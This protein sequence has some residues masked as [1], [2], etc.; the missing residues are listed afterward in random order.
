MTPALYVILA[1]ALALSLLWGY[2]ATVWW[3][4]RKHGGI[5]PSDLQQRGSGI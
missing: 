5:V 1:Y 3:R 4:L 2:A